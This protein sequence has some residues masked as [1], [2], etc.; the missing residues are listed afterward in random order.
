MRGL[1]LR[2]TDVLFRPDTTRVL[3]RSFIP[4]DPVRVENIIW[5][6]LSLTE[7]E[8]E[9][10]LAGVTT[11]FGGRHLGMHAVWRRHFELVKAHVPQRVQLSETRQLYI[12]A[13]FSGEYALESAALFN[14]SIVPHP[15]Q[16]ALGEGDLRFILSLRATGEGHISSI[17]FRTGVI[18]ADGSIEVETP[19]RFVTAPAVNPNPTYRKPILWDSSTRGLA[20]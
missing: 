14:P 5:R 2:P 15:D 18:R 4:N 17:E 16:S 3:I 13:L 10:E 19:S 8:C 6:A 9:R 20:V 1:T 7:G 11:E 12:G